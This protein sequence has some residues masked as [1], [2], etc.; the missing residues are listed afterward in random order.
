MSDR[1]TAIVAVP[2]DHALPLDV[3]CVGLRRIA[4]ERMQEIATV[5]ENT[6]RMKNTSETAHIEFGGDVGVV[7]LWQNNL[8]GAVFVADG[9]AR[10][11]VV[12]GVAHRDP[13]TRLHSSAA[14]V[15]DP[16]SKDGS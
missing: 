2:A 13:V 14:V 3:Q 1:I 8:V 10:V 5:D 15:R 7:S 16:Y 4:I 12:G 11:G 9:T 6:V